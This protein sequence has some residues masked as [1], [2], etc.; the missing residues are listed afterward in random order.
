MQPMSDGV[1]RIHRSILIND[2][3]NHRRGG[4]AEKSMTTKAQ[5]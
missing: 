4:H 3:K 2:K 1:I 5:G